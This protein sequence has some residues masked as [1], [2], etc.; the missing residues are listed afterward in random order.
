MFAKDLTALLAAAIPA[1]LNV[2]ITGAPGIGKTDIAA[3]AAQATGYE[4]LLSHPAVQDPTAASGLPWFDGKGGATHLPFGNLAR[5]INAS[6]PTV[7]F[8]DD[9]G[10]AAPAVQAAYMQLLLARE[11]DGQRI[12]DHVTFLAATNRR[13]DRAGVTG[14]LEPVKSRFKTIVELQADIESWREWAM[15]SGIASELIAFLTFRPELLCAFKPSAEMCNS[16]LPRTWAAVDAWLKCKLPI[17][18]LQPALAGAVGPEAATEF[19][20]FYEVCHHMPDPL[21]VLQNPSN[22]PVP[23]EASV[24]WALTAALAEHVARTNTDTGF[25]AAATYA[26]RMV[27]MDAGEMAAVLIKDIMKRASSAASSMAFIEL[28]TDRSAGLTELLV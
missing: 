14:I 25:Q 18:L 4:L 9:L 8:L 12:S 11:L 16:P 27:G 19:L 2:L 6:K 22:A 23:T 28:F 15:V 1:R 10:Q 3:A 13:S 26:R 5:A 20:A 21:K 17:Y 24:L 7:W